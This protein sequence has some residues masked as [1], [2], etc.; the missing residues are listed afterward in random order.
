MNLETVYKAALGIVYQYIPNMLKVITEKDFK[1]FILKSIEHTNIDGRGGTPNLN[2]IASFFML[3]EASRTGKND[4]IIKEF[5]YFN[6]LLGEF[7]K[8]NSNQKEFKNLVM[9]SLMNFNKEA[10]FL[11][12]LGEVGACLSLA[13]ENIFE[14]YEYS[15][16]N[17]KSI[18][19]KFETKF[20]V[21]L[22]E[23]S[24]I[25]Y[26]AEKYEGSDS[27]KV[28]MHRRLKTKFEEKSKGLDKEYM[29]L[30][31]IYPIIH[32]ISNEIIKDN[33]DLLKNLNE[34]TEFNCYEP[35]FFGNIQGT[36]FKLFSVDEVCKLP[37]P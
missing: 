22:V 5:E 36:F 4:I 30:I 31:F 37:N 29:D 10:A 32:G 16:P 12:V 28:F 9:A 35:C 13:R 18:D 21:R 20:G 34:N 1:N 27:F 6:Y 15:L 3:I 17:N 19:L 24:N 14:K 23:V 33:H 25:Q 7:I 8:L 11:E 26:K 2:F